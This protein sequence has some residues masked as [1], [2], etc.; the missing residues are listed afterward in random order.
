MN[1]FPNPLFA[2][3][4]ESIA[5][6]ITMFPPLV[7]VAT[8]MPNC[9]CPSVNTLPVLFFMYCENNLNY[10]IPVTKNSVLLFCALPSSVVLSEIGFEAP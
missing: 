6:V 8:K 1:C 7:S 3:T 5:Q 4:N 10:Q 9:F 2:K